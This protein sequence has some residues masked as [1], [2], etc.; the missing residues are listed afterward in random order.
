MPGRFWGSLTSSEIPELAAAILDLA[1]TRP[2]VVVTTPGHTTA[3]RIPDDVL[4]EAETIVQE[5]GDI[6][7]VA[8]VA[9]GEV[10]YTLEDLLPPKWHIF[11]GYCRS[12]PTGILANPEIHRSPLRHRRGN[13]VA[14]EQVINDALGHALEA[15]AFEGV[16]KGRVTVTGRVLGFLFDGEQALIDVGAT[17]PAVLWRDATIPGVPLDWVLAKD[18]EVRGE[19][20]RERNTCSH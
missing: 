6:A 12:Y 20:D 4:R 16:A 8:I 17:M 3:D 5:I 18:G 1:R 2:I 14:S 11:N 13:E 19:W 10:S 9:T 7:D 15:G